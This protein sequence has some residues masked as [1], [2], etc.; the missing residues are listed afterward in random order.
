MDIENPESL[1][2]KFEDVPPFFFIT[3]IPDEA[4]PAENETMGKS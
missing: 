2:R 4:A 3:Q 1:W